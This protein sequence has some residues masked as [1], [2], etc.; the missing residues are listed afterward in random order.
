M[1][2]QGSILHGAGT[3]PTLLTS[4]PASH[5]LPGAHSSKIVLKKKEEG[6]ML[7]AAATVKGLPSP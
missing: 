4:L 7:G 2:P 3:S 1:L 5:C 6:C